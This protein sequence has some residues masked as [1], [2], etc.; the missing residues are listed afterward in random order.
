MD[1]GICSLSPATKSGRWYHD[2]DLGV[3]FLIFPESITLSLC[4]F[5]GCRLTLAVLGS[6]PWLHLGSHL[7]SLGIQL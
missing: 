4:R 3:V 6:L 2:V 7:E 1:P 5:H